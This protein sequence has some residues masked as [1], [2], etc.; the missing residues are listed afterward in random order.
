MEIKTDSQI[1]EPEEN[2]NDSRIRLKWAI[3]LISVIVIFTGLIGF[4]LLVGKDKKNQENF[5]S[6][7]N[8]VDNKGNDEI[9][10]GSQSNL[11]SMIKLE[12]QAGAPIMGKIKEIGNDKLKITLLVLQIGR[13]SCRERV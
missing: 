6:A 4:Y 3:L 9:R 13:A 12:D 10:S 7:P 11:D 8:M 2:K 5:S 1:S